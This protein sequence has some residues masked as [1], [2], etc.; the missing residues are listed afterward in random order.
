[1]KLVGVVLLILVAVVTSIRGSPLATDNLLVNLTVTL[2]LL[3]LIVRWV[4]RRAVVAP[5]LGTPTAYRD[6]IFRSATEAAW[7]ERFDRDGVQ[8]RY[9]PTWFK[10]RR[11]GR[12]MGYLPDFELADGSFVEIKGTAPTEE[13]QWKCQQLADITGREV[14]LLAGW[15]GRHSVYRFEPA[16]QRIS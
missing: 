4:R 3:W 14:K 8:W 2:V 10:L 5:R 15:P 11:N 9:E 6:V 1:V 16:R 7:A 13:E 12:R